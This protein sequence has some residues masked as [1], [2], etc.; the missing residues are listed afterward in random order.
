MLPEHFF[1]VTPMHPAA[2]GLRREQRVN[3]A[4]GISDVEGKVARVAARKQGR[5]RL[6][7]RRNWAG[8]TG[9]RMKG[10]G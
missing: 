10:Q 6:G 8:E 1:F 7:E 4:D 2:A 5:G 9:L 3:G